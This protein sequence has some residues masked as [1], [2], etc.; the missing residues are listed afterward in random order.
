MDMKN[1]LITDPLKKPSRLKL[2]LFAMFS[3]FF[4][5]FLGLYLVEAIFLFINPKIG[6]VRDWDSRT[7]MEVYQDGK[8]ND[9]KLAVPIFPYL[10]INEHSDKIE[11]FFDGH[12]PVG[13]VENYLTYLCNESGEYSKF[14]SDKFGLNNS[15]QVYQ[16]DKV[17]L[18]IGDSFG[19]GS[20]VDKEDTIAHLLEEKSNQAILNLSYSGNGPLLALKTAV[21]ILPTVDGDIS[22]LTYLYFAGNDFE[23][24]RD[25]LGNAHLVSYLD[26][27]NVEKC[28]VKGANIKFEDGAKIKFLDYLLSKS[29]EGRSINEHAARLKSFLLMRNLRKTFIPFSFKPHPLSTFEWDFVAFEK[30][31][32]KFA[33]LA[34]DRNV[35]KV[36]VY[37]PDNEGTSKHY[38]FD[39]NKSKVLSVAKELGFSIVDFEGHAKQLGLDVRPPRM[40]GFGHHNPK[41]NK[42]LTEIIVSEIQK[43][44]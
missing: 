16:E 7:L 8:L 38:N 27:K 42:I 36:F 34:D 30:I 29:A 11:K 44:T 41:A 5:T 35:P 43:K 18:L 13:G 39:Y 37:L 14:N 10:F 25:E 4:G 28:S 9:E 12:Y 24:L 19:F 17:G 1:K 32:F 22:F 15:N 21:D 23:N 2:L 26:C 33:S 31:L 3:L 6:F 40:N 20:C